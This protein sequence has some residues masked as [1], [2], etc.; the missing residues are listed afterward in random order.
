[1]KALRL[2]LRRRVGRQSWGID[3]AIVVTALRFPAEDPYFV[4]AVLAD[5]VE[6]RKRVFA[7]RD[8]VA[9]TAP[10]L[11]AVV[12]RW[13]APPWFGAAGV[14]LRCQP[15]DPLL[16]EGA[17]RAEPLKEI[18]RGFQRLPVVPTVKVYSGPPVK[19]QC[20]FL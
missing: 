9:L 8:E 15:A 6:G 12:Q 19:T 18:C 2:R 13:V 10:A 14:G 1:M 16:R 4:P 3:W 11:R 20:Q 5:A 7:W 17:G